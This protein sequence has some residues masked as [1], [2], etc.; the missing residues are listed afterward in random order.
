MSDKEIAVVTG[1][2][3][4]IGKAISRR[5]KSSG[6]EIVI[7]DISK[8]QAEA[9]ARELEGSYYLCDVRDSEQV[10]AAVKEIIE[11]HGKIDILVNNAGITS[12]ALLMRMKDGDWDR[13]IDINLKGVFNF[14]REVLRKSMLKN[15]KGSIINIASIVG[16]IGNPGQANYSASKAGVIALSKTAAKEGASRGV[17]VNAVAPGFIETRMTE[18]LSGSV[19]K[20][21]LKNIPLNRMGTGD[22]VADAVEFL[23]SDK[24]SYITGQVLKVDGGMVM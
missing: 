23:A 3:M 6:K 13:V 1:G 20:D 12:D 19:K 2:A 18:K 21:F 15:R 14:T 22:E 16:I 7:I 24:A 4:G 8:E 10:A 5:L 17:R 11:K 9:A